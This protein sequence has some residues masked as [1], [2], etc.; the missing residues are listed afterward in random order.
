MSIKFK[1]TPDRFAEACNVIEYLTV[2][3][4]DRD[5]AMRIAP[6]FIVDEAGEYVV[7]VKLDAD[8]DIE[9]MENLGDALLTMTGVT[10]KR[11]EK[12]CNEFTEAAKAIV[13]PPNAGGSNGRMSTD[14]QK[15][16]GG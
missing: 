8:G 15:P 4:G 5:V 13:N 12:L 7:K 16:P 14:T 10:P 3:A 6:R 11:L 2:S 9:S 1:I